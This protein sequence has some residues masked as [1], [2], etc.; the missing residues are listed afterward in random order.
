VGKKAWISL[1]YY[2]I[3]KLETVGWLSISSRLACKKIMKDYGV[4]SQH[5]TLS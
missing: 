4:R 5:L 2:P 3:E 1:I